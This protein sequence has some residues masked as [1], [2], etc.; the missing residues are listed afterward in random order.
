ME[1][2]RPEAD[3]VVEK[4][5]DEVETFYNE[6]TPASIRRKAREWGIIYV[7]DIQLTF[8]IHAKDSVSNNP[9]EAVVCELTETGNT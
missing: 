2:Q 5:W 6:E 7:S 9:I 3:A 4:V 8:N 1:A